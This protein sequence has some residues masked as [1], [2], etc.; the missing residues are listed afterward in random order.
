MAKANMT[1]SAW[2][3]MAS[4]EK[5]NVTI[6]VGGEEKVITVTPTISFED[7]AEI[8]ETVAGVVLDEDTGEYHPEVQDVLFRAK[9]LEKYA[10]FSIPKSFDKI[11]KLVYTTDVYKLVEKNINFDQLCDITIAIGEIITEKTF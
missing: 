8:V 1:I 6:T 3:K 5:K 4:N 7:A 9:A 11:Y 10:G 2:E